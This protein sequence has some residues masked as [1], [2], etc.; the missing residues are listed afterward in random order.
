[1]LR[2][3]NVSS[4]LVP[5]R[6][7]GTVSAAAPLT[8]M[9]FG[10]GGGGGSHGAGHVTEVHIDTV[11]KPTHKRSDF[12]YGGSAKAEDVGARNEA[13]FIGYE[14][15]NPS[16]LTQPKIFF[17][18]PHLVNLLT[19]APVSVAFVLIAAAGW[20]IACWRFYA[21]KNFISIV[22]ERPAS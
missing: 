15:I 3:V 9:R 17:G 7:S 16:L 8:S 10:G 19:I 5:R 2:R 14:P 11:A 20:G 12:V 1:M 21:S 6:V 18:M 22:V 13:A 4:A